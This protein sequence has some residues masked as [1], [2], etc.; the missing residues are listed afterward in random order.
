M[1]PSCLF[2]RFV[3][4]HAF[5]GLLLLPLL[6]GPVGIGLAQAA[7]ENDTVKAARQATAKPESTKPATPTGKEPSDAK[8]DKG[9]SAASKATGGKSDTEKA[10]ASKP[11]AKKS[12]ANQKNTKPKAGKSD[13][14]G[15]G[16][17]TATPASAKKAAGDTVYDNQPPVTDKELMSFL[18][19]LPRF[20][21]WAGENK[22]EARPLLR[23]GKADFLYSPKAAEWVRAQ[24]WDPVRFFCVM[25][26][27]A[28]SLVIV[29]EGNDMKGTR[30]TD[31]PSV[32]EAEL[33]LARRHL[34]EMLK[35]GGDAPAINR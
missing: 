27:M 15:A 5:V 13:R 4:P 30:P 31:M 26:R 12:D 17:G 24:G 34:G 22:E 19:I 23:N 28:A 35:A 14:S 18:E 21:A 3:R 20:R 11:K 29:A 2:I 32:T 7:Q 9:K 16:K 10:S 1:K 8:A 6:A 25:G 33:A